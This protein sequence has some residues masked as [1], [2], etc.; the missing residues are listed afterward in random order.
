[1]EQ[2]V[3]VIVVEM[4]QQLKRQTGEM[5]EEEELDQQGLILVQVQEILEQLVEMDYKTLLAEQQFGILE[6]EL[7]LSD[8]DLQMAEHPQA[9]LA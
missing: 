6:E 5:Q 3:R 1:V 4:H 7:R 8:L 9:I 2:V